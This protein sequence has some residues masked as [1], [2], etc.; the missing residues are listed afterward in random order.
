MIRYKSLSLLTL[1][2][3]TLLIIILFSSCDN[4]LLDIYTQV[5]TDYSGSRTIDLAI[6]TQYLQ[7]GEVALDKNES[8]YDKIL[9]SLPPGKLRHMKKRII[10]ILNP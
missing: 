10:H 6:K 4:T 8:L 7:K 9:T 1:S 2:I 5:N 3:I